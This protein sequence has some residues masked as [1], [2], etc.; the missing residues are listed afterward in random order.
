MNDEIG[1]LKE[2]LQFLDRKLVELF[3]AFDAFR[4]ETQDRLAHVDEV[5]LRNT[6]LE[7]EVARLRM[8]KATV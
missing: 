7:A 5:I 3:G 6:A 1:D 8:E 4:T 2:Q